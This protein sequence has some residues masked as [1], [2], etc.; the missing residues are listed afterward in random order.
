[1]A[2]KIQEKLTELLHSMHEKINS[3]EA[4]VDMIEAR[5]KAPDLHGMITGLETRMQMLE[6]GGKQKQTVY[7]QPTSTKSNP[8]TLQVEEYL[9]KCRYVQTP[10]FKKISTVNEMKKD[11]TIKDQI[12]TFCE[13]Y[14]AYTLKSVRQAINAYYSE[15]MK[16]QRVVV[17]PREV[18][19][20]PDYTSKEKVPDNYYRLKTFDIKNRQNRQQEIRAGRS[21]K[22][23]DAG[24]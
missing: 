14:P 2:T 9:N 11:E 4:Q 20:K 22:N 16:Q 6:A 15:Y 17:K 5:K 13:K 8:I 10:A 7:V 23:Q 1:M 21:K 18:I 19:P 3:L 12:N 24:P